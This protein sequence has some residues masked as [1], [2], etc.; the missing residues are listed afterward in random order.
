MK[1]E[2]INYLW[3]KGVRVPG[4][5]SKKELIKNVTQDEYKKLVIGY[6]TFCMKD[7]DVQIS[8]LE[9]MFND[10]KLHLLNIQN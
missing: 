6:I 1:N 10:I 5:L 9:K 2:I 3:K 4:Y 7:G 8:D